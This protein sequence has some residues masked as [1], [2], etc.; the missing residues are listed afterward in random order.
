MLV[1]INCRNPVEIPWGDCG[2][3]YVVESSGVFT[4]ME[5]ASSHLQVDLLLR[6]QRTER[7]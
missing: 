2:A 7:K 3:D 6:K 4:T 1:F 5:K